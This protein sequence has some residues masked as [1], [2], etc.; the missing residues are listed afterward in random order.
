MRVLS[1]RIKERKK[2]HFASISYSKFS[3]LN[4]SM[5]LHCNI[6]VNL[7]TG[8]FESYNNGFSS[9]ELTEVLS[10]TESTAQ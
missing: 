4:D 6:S 5:K 3:S 1:W 7:H 9:E 2:E 10:N 8:K